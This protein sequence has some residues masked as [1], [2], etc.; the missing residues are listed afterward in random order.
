MIAFAE[1]LIMSVKHTAREARPRNG[2]IIILKPSKIQRK[3]A[4]SIEIN[5]LNNNCIATHNS[6]TYHL[7][8]SWLE[9]FLLVIWRFLQ[10]S[11][12]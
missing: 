4:R 2:F 5:L 12:T 7:I 1:V 11:E 3:D 10:R 9:D 6:C 8:I